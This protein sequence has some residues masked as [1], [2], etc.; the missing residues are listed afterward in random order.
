MRPGSLHSLEDWD[1][2][3]ARR[4]HHALFGLSR[5]LLC[6]VSK[7]QQRFL[8]LLDQA[9]KGIRKKSVAHVGSHTL[10]AT[11]MPCISSAFRHFMLLCA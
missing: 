9:A 4:Q 7:Q 5:R 3:R 10:Q 11:R 2:I 6:Q 1:S 8:E